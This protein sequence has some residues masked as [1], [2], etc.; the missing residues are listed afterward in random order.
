MTRVLKASEV[1][2]ARTDLL[3]RL[4]D[5]FFRRIMDAMGEMEFGRSGGER[6]K[7]SK[8]IPTYALIGHAAR[9][10]ECYR[11]THDMGLVLEHAANSL[12]EL[13][14]FDPMLAPSGCGFVSF[15]K[16]ITVID[17]RGKKMLVHF[18]LWGHVNTTHGPG[19]ATYCFND[20]WREPDEVHHALLQQDIWSEDGERAQE[21][22]LKASGRWA[23]VG[24]SPMFK[25]QRL[26]PPRLMP[27]EEQQAALIADGDTPVAG[28]QIIRYVHALW[29]LMNQTVARVEP[30]HV[31]RPA[32]R[33]AER[34]KLP[35]KVSVIKLRREQ[36]SERQRGESDI[37]WA[38]RWVVKGHWRWQAVSEHH[39]LAQE[40]EPGKFR[41]RIWINPFVK[42]PADKPIVQSQKIYSLE[43]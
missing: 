24:F 14:Q 18:L 31:E 38:H 5:P 12:D 37:E 9:T 3:D 10:A 29:L 21:T 30:D 6:R 19:I 22:Y 15:D 20:I 17:M 16:P 11:V 34:R 26:G 41:A 28:T 33:R 7:P 1:L 42:G 23:T 8:Q 40:I 25:G 39:H 36:G 43:R 4:E 35:P 32:R 27:S 13:D 2:D